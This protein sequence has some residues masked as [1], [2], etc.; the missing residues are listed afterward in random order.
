MKTFGL[1]MVS[2]LLFLGC[3]SDEIPVGAYSFSEN[4]WDQKVK[5]SF[6]LEL[7]ETELGGLNFYY[8]KSRRDGI[9]QITFIEDPNLG[10]REK[11]GIVLDGL[12]ANILRRTRGLPRRQNGGERCG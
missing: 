6:E 5:P 10:Y 4:K 8:P 3:Q 7:G 2:V 9:L 11:F 1:L 12:W